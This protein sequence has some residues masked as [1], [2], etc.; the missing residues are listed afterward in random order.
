MVLSW[1]LPSFDSN[2]AA[3]AHTHLF[4]SVTHTINANTTWSS[5]LQC[6]RTF[7]LF[8][9]YRLQLQRRRIVHMLCVCVHAEQTLNL[10][11][12]TCNSMVAASIPGRRGQNTSVFSPSQQG[13]LSVVPSTGPEINNT[14]K[15]RRCSKAL[16][17][18]HM[19][20]NVWVKLSSGDN[21]VE[22][23]QQCIQFV[24]NGE[25]NR[26]YKSDF[27]GVQIPYSV[28]IS[29]LWNDY[30]Y[31]SLRISPN[32]TRGSEMWYI[33]RLVFRKPYTGSR[34]SILECTD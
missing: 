7:A 28:S 34:Y 31:N 14:G 15:V 22:H 5:V 25:W 30:I 19:W 12:W 32:F 23:I 16:R 3:Y 18:F 20:T 8:C 4:A 9:H 29:A 1:W 11:R 13:Q 6:C 21:I 26:K 17:S 33:L 2:Y 10:G 24:F 27:R